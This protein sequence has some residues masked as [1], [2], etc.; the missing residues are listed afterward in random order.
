MRT[1]Q[2]IKRIS[3]CKSVI[4]SCYLN[5]RQKWANHSDKWVWKRMT[6]E[7]NKWSRRKETNEYLADS[8]MEV[9][10]LWLMKGMIWS[11]QGNLLSL[12][13][14]C[15]QDSNDKDKRCHTEFLIWP[16]GISKNSSDSFTNLI[17]LR[18][19]FALIVLLVCTYT[20]TE[21][22]LVCLPHCWPHSL[23]ACQNVYPNQ[24][25]RKNAQISLP[26]PMLD[27]TAWLYSLTGVLP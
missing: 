5:I 2:R 8:L 16:H 12:E 6:M 7:E 26:A 3:K 15:G 18:N 11:R 13:F 10:E 17:M 22:R 24:G 19:L 25:H 23:N 9:Q 1:Y 20:Y 27:P 4:K 14:E 21:D